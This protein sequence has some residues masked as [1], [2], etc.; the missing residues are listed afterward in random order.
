[1]KVQEFGVVAA[2]GIVFVAVV[3]WVVEV[4]S[5]VAEVS[6]VVEVVLFVAG[7]S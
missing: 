7:V 4:V 1:V 5:F 6:W 2:V 3:S